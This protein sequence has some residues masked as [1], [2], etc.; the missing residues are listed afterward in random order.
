LPAKQHQELSFP[1]EII[2]SAAVFLCLAIGIVLFVVLY[3]RRV[4][5]HQIQ[6]REFNRQKQ[7][8]L[9]QASIRSEEDER[10]RIATELHDDVGATLS[11][12]R[13]FLHQALRHPEEATLGNQT[14]NLLDESIRKVRDLSH[15]LQPGTLQY[16]G[17]IKALESYAEIITRSGKIRMET[18]LNA[19]AWQE[20]DPQTALAIYRIIQELVS[21]VIKHADAFRIRLENGFIEDRRCIRVTHDGNGLTEA[22]Y[23]EQLYKKG[24]IGLKNIEHRLQSAGMSIAF[25]DPEAGICTT[26]IS[27]PETPPSSLKTS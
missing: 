14:R 15:Q 27:F 12:V 9:M 13:L 6:L 11:S 2:A 10:M 3:Q 26:V 21:N 5:H 7:I 22:A 23:H 16:L 1:T 17:L 20:P 8:E 4:I 24:G 19:D 25:P 18:A